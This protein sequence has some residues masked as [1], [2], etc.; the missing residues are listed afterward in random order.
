MIA[1]KFLKIKYMRLAVA[2]LAAALLSLACQARHLLS[3]PAYP[4][5]ASD[6]SA[7][8]AAAGGSVGFLQNG[9]QYSTCVTVTFNATNVTYFVVY[10]LYSAYVPLPLGI[11]YNL[12]ISSYVSTCAWFDWQLFV[13]V[14]ETSN[15]PAYTTIPPFNVY[16]PPPPST[17]P[18]AASNANTTLAAINTSAA[19]NAIM[20]SSCKNTS[21]VLAYTAYN[22]YYKNYYCVT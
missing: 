14:F 21:T 12:T 11:V 17:P 18:S 10:G 19:A 3:S 8:I 1:P 13:G 6:Y 15:R 2:V 7:S 20:N 9:G 22:Y 5:N 4:V 16:T